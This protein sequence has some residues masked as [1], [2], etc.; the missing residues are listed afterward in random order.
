MKLIKTLLTAIFLFAAIGVSAQTAPRVQ[1]FEGGLSVGPTFALGPYH[2]YDM[3]VLVY[4]ALSGRYNFQEKPWDVGIALGLNMAGWGVAGEQYEQINSNIFFQV[5]SH[6]NFRQGRKVNPYV[7][8]GAGIATTYGSD[9]RDYDGCN[10][11]I[12][13]EI[14]IELMYHLRLNLAFNI[15]RKGFNTCAITIGFVI[16]GRPKKE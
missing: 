4:T 10:A 1:K 11:L 15:C 9:L 13:P 16:G 2:S 6:Y 12:T 7:G 5:N 14:G 3:N 8:I